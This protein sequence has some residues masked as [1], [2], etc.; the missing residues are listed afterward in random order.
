MNQFDPKHYQFQRQDPFKLGF[1]DEDQPLKPT[2]G[3]FIIGSLVLILAF[4]A[5]GSVLFLN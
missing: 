1:W 2:K 3:E 4:I 5:I